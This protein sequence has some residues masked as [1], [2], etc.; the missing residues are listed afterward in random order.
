MLLF[1]FLYWF[2]SFLSRFFI[3]FKRN[4][5]SICLSLAC[6]IKFY[7]AQMFIFLL[8]FSKIFCCLLTSA[9]ALVSA[10]LSLSFKFICA[11]LAANNLCSVRKWITSVVE[12][13]FICYL[14]RKSGY[15]LYVHSPF[16][17]SS[18]LLFHMSF[19]NSSKSFLCNISS[20][21]LRS[22]FCCILIVFIATCE[23]SDG[24]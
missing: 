8:W 23:F 9:H 10:R 11:S 6:N 1:L 18:H 4:W 17:I 22:I 15:I 3:S 2:S 5:D 20:Y 19:W 12:C 16:F 13:W 24:Y 7:V 14:L 21:L